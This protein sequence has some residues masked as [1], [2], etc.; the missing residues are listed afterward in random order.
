M[1]AET[2]V[3]TGAV[4]E[5]LGLAKAPT[6]PLPTIGKA[7]N[8]RRLNI[9]DPGPA[10]GHWIDREATIEFLTRRSR[11]AGGVP[12]FERAITDLTEATA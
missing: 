10:H 12:A 3:P 9:K 4:H 5:R 1:S 2:L 6:V 8:V 7:I 11:E